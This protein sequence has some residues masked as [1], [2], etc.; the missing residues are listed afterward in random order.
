MKFGLTR[1]LRLFFRQ[2]VSPIIFNNEFA[3]DSFGTRENGQKRVLAAVRYASK[4]VYLR[5]VSEQYPHSAQ[6]ALQQKLLLSVSFGFGQIASASLQ[7][8]PQPAQSLLEYFLR[9]Y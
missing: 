4:I 8:V 7:F 9:S 2:S 6:L 5:V 1:N 3:R